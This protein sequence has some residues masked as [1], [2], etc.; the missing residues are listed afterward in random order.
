[1]FCNRFSVFALDLSLDRDV[2][3]QARR[4]AEAAMPLREM[5]EKAC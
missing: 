5:E 1:V 3:T 2:L 4:S